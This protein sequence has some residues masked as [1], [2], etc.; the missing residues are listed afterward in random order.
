MSDVPPVKLADEKDLTKKEIAVDKAAMDQK[1]DHASRVD[2]RK[3]YTINHD[4]KVINVGKV[5]R[6]SMPYLMGYFGKS[7][8]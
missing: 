3:I 4:A 5:S 8:S 1:L 2:F 6:T 7:M